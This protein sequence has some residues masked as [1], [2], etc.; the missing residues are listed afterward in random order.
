MGCCDYAHRE[1]WVSP[2]LI[3]MSLDVVLVHEITHAVT[4]PSHGRRFTARMRL[5][6][7]DA[8]D[9]DLAAALRAVA[10]ACWDPLPTQ[11]G[12]G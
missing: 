8:R 11:Q 1:I 2:V 12:L 3:G 4:G 10:T 6:A 5:A 9:P 7:D